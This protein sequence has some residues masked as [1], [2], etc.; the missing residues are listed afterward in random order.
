MAEDKSYGISSEKE[1]GNYCL[2]LK[3]ITRNMAGEYMCKAT[4]EM[5]EASTVG[6]LNVIGKNKIYLFYDI[7]IL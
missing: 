2:K 1:T 7:I 3:K 6:K 5:G 4:N